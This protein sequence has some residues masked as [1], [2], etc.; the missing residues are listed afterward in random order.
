MRG[1][2]HKPHSQGQFLVVGEGCKIDESVVIG[3]LVYIG[4]RVKINA[5]VVIGSLVHISDDTV[6]G[7]DTH[8]AG[9]AYLSPA[10]VIGRRCIVGPGATLTNDRFPPVRRTTGVA[11]WEGVTMEDD[12]VLGAR[13]TVLS[14]VTIGQGAVVGMGAVVLKD[15]PPE[16]VVTGS[17]ARVICSR[18]EYE[19]RQLERSGGDSPDLDELTGLEGLSLTIR[20]R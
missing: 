1:P 10:S 11:A 3:N 2:N 9:S 12:A 15:V 8:I 7:E 5:N 16:M 4:K 20:D 6:I 17:P 14:G 13:S 18:V 19:R